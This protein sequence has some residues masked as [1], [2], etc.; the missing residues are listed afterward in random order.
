MLK[1]I[2][3]FQIKFRHF[4]NSSKIYYKKVANKKITH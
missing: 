1:D 4:K 3:S 2:L